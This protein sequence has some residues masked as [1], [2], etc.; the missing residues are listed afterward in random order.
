M[1]NVVFLLLALSF[2]VMAQ[3]QMAVRVNEKGI[4]K[5]MLM[6][7]KYNT[8]QQNARS[9]AIPANLYKFTVPRSTMA[10]N[11][12]V[13]ILNEV[14]NVN[15]NRD[16]DF[17]LHTAAINVTGNVNPQSLRTE[18]TNSGTNGF[19]FKLSVSIPSVVAT[20]PNISLCEDRV[21]GVKKCGNGL[22]ATVANL[23][24]NT[25]GRPVTLSATMRLRTDNGVARVKVIK[26]SSNLESKAGP[27]LN[28]N[29]GSVTVPPISI[30]VDGVETRLDTSKIR[31]EVVKRKSFLA[32]KLMSFAADFIADDLAE[33]LNVYLVHR[34]VVTSWEVFRK[35]YPVT[36]DEYL[37]N[38]HVQGQYQRHPLPAQVR[39]RPG[40]AIEQQ[41]ADIIKN[42]QVR[43]ALSRISTP[44]NKDIELY[45]QLGLMLNNHV[46][47]VRNTLGNS[48]RQLPGLNLNGQRTSD[49]NFA[50][51][52]PLINGALDLVN[53]TGLYQEVFNK[54][55][56][57]PGFTIKNVK[58]HFTP[59]NTGVL[60]VNS[61][62]D[63]NK[64]KSAGIAEWLKNLI[65]AWLE[66]N[67]NKSVIYFPIEIEVTPSLVRAA[68]GGVN[69]NMH[70]GS[71]F[72]NNGLSN[73]FH[74][75]SNVDR[76]TN[77]VRDG[78]MKKLKESLLQHVNKTYTLDVSRF[79]NQSG[80]V[81]RPNYVGVTQSAYLMMNLDIVDIKF[82]G[83][84]PGIR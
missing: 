29:F 52:E 16:L 23:R 57:T 48:N 50:F 34:S 60:I 62:V 11:P 42:A 81:F 71:P 77:I 7:L 19:D 17:Y 78:V 59:R 9:F 31:N 45:G 14:S 67:N 74:Y 18:I 10:S 30:I 35:D 26:V 73:D 46:M 55:S 21:K 15:L 3:D 80:V 20:G 27:G 84:N 1:K 65:A 64:L 56:P 6:A 22:K 58:L 33:M 61:Q 66:R 12:V 63:L 43:V 37:S 75:P 54:L 38:H 79:M 72:E 53:S 40:G 70:L 8:N 5:S 24:I 41:I 83:M 25:T 32:Q 76:M 47:N 4:L 68:N 51:S 49:L 44:M 82:S 36:F 28:V 13:Q 69:L 2:S 39:T